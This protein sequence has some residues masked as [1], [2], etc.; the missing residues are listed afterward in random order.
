MESHIGAAPISPAWRAGML[1]DLLMGHGVGYR[2]RS[3]SRALARRGAT[4]TPIRPLTQF[5]LPE[6]RRVEACVVIPCPLTVSNRRLMI[7]SQL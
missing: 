2:L 6:N 3:G 4:I 1:A 5:A 7:T